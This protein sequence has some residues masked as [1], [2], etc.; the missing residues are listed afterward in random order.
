MK[1]A[2]RMD[3]DQRHLQLLSKLQ[4]LFGILS[5]FGTVIF[6]WAIKV[7]SDAARDFLEQ[8]RT[9]LEASLMIG[10]GVVLLLIGIAI[11]FCIILAGQSLARYENYRFCMIVAICE[12]PMFPF[13]TMLGIATIV[14]LLRDS[15][16]KL[17]LKNSE[18][19]QPAS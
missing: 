11:L 8:S 16:K 4:I 10:F 15:V 9:E 18:E 5:V 17:F 13:G 3:R 14:V 19:S 2:L 7:V 1:W 6:Y 12:C